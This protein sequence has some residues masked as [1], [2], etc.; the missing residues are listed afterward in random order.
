MNIEEHR[1]EPSFK[2][3][4]NSI[5]EEFSYLCS[6]CEKTFNEEIYLREHMNHHKKE[7]QLEC[8]SCGKSFTSN[9]YLTRHKKIHSGVKPYKCKTCE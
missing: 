3:N 6:I 8:G 5:M 2:A 1:L 7:K 9:Q 4:R